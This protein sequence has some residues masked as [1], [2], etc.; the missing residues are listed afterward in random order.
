MSPIG[1]MQVTDSLSAG[2]LERVAVTL[3]NQLPQMQYRSH[4]CATRSAG[5]LVQSLAPHVHRL[6]LRRSGRFDAGA[7]LRLGRYLRQ[8]EIRLVHAHGT[9]LFISVLATR[10]LG[11]IKV[12]WHDHFGRYATDQ[13]PVWIYRPIA[14]MACG[15]IAVNQPLADWARNRLR[16]APE[17]VWQL[18]NCACLPAADS[19]ATGL[20]GQPG[21][22]IVCVANLR[23]EKDH[24]NLLQAMREIVA[25]APSAHLILVGQA[26]NTSHLTRLRQEMDRGDLSSKVTWLG[27]RNDVAA[28]LKACDIGVLSSRSEGLPLALLEYGQ[29]GLATVATRIG[30]C[31]AVL[32]QGRVGCLVSPSAPRELA[33]AILR[34]LQH[35]AEREQLGKAFQQRVNAHYSVEHVIDRICQVYAEVLK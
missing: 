2:G 8:N 31:P 9:S 18:P 16:V 27:P 19:P 6:E 24:L 4:L 33:D 1:V 10:G 22:R 35:P 14:R 17:R 5:P 11:G 7:V 30:E 34:L 26:D 32:D 23:P 21:W 28:I 12:L 15:V 25:K 3:A 29:A 20:P 13:R